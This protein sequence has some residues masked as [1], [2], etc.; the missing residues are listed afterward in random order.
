MKNS[1][2][3]P[4]STAL[5]S[6]ALPVSPP[7]KLVE[8]RGFEPLTCCVQGS[9]SS[10]LSYT[11]QER[12]NPKHPVH[13]SSTLKSR[14]RSCDFFMVGP[15]GL[16]PSASALSGL[17]SSQLSYGPVS[18]STTPVSTEPITARPD[19]SPGPMSPAPGFAP[20]S[21]AGTLP[22]FLWS[23]VLSKSE[24]NFS[25]AS[26]LADIQ[27]PAVRMPTTTIA[28]GALPVVAGISLTCPAEL[29]QFRQLCEVRIVPSIRG[30]SSPNFQ[31]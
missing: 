21:S 26:R 19:P 6:T 14:V 8:V 16:E 9:R 3:L 30:S 24:Q 29:Q 1:L 13:E 28:Y 25:Q 27:P 23:P 20:A 12:P 15:D 7:A 4:C 31:V 10:H 5:P 2:P 22:V 18:S 11:P 17:R